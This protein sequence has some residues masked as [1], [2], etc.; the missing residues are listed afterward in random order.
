MQYK[1]PTWYTTL[2]QSL[3]CCINM[4]PF[5]MAILIFSIYKIEMHA[6]NLLINSQCF[7]LVKG[8]HVDDFINSTVDVAQFHCIYVGLAVLFVERYRAD[9]S[10]QNKVAQCKSFHVW[11]DDVDDLNRQQVHVL[12]FE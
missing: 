2:V 7:E 10:L 1:H 3:F 11:F 4:C 9:K 5:Y 6:Y 12:H 8:I